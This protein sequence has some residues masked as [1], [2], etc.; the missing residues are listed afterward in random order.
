[1]CLR[2][3]AMFV[4]ADEHIKFSEQLEDTVGPI[5]EIIKFNMKPEEANQFLKA[6]EK[7]AGKVGNFTYPNGTVAILNESIGIEKGNTILREIMK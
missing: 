4:Q 5:V 7:D 6:W 1:M 3:M 2:D